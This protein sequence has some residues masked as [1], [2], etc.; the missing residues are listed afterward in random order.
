VGR[1]AVRARIAGG[2]DGI[3]T[4]IVERVTS[5]APTLETGGAMARAGTNILDSGQRLPSMGMDTVFHGPIALPEWFGGRW[6]VLL[7]YRAH[8]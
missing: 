7:V 4:T 3:E 5:P 6:G 8:W 1:D 2:G